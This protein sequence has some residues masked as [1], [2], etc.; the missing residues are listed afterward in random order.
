MMLIIIALVVGWAVPVTFTGLISNIGQ[1]SE[2]SWLRWIGDVPP[3][4]TSIVQGVLPPILLALLLLV[5]PIV[6]RLL[7]KTQGNLTGMAVELSVQKSYFAFLF[8]QV[9]GLQPLLDINHG[10][11][12]F[13]E[14]CASFLPTL[15][16]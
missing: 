3:S 15:T 14:A 16:K 10:A 1:L 8:I 2:I 12:L 9:C 13:I 7:S 4:V 6:L 5:L 11:F